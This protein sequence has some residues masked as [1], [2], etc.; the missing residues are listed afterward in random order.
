MQFCTQ[1][2]ILSIFQSPLK[3][4]HWRTSNMLIPQNAFLRTVHLQ[5]GERAELTKAF[6]QSDV[7]TFSELTGDTNPLHL[8][9]DF[10]KDNKFGKLVVHGVLVCG[11]MSAVLGTK[12]PGCVLLSQ[13]LRF[14]APLYIGEQAS[15]IADVIKIR[16]SIAWIAVSCIVK[17]TKKVIMKGEVKI[18]LPENRDQSV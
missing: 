14:L 3:M 6:S 10:A 5:V 15:A 8:N 9:E 4:G 13:E 2:V 18:M 17:E 16:R 11:L 7:F 12:V 1:R